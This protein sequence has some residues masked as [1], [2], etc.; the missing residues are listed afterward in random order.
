MI[1]KVLAVVVAAAFLTSCASINGVFVSLQKGMNYIGDGGLILNGFQQ[2]FLQL[3]P[4]SNAPSYCTGFTPK[5]KAASASAV[6]AYTIA[7]DGAAAANADP[8]AV[9]ELAAD[10][11]EAIFQVEQIVLLA[12]AKSGRRGDSAL[13]TAVTIAG[14]TFTVGLQVAMSVTFLNQKGATLDDLR[15]IG[16]SLS[17]A[18][19]QIQGR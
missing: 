15:S 16:V 5:M 7:V 4:E 11:A 12:Q 2:V 14:V 13:H 6:R 10:A 3:C 1:K 9:G 18:D 8:A 19:G 17:Q